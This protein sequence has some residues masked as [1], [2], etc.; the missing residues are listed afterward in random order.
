M[1]TGKGLGTDDKRH[2]SNDRRRRKSRDRT[3][4][5]TLE[6]QARGFNSI[7]QATGQ[8]T[9]NFETMAFDNVKV[10]ADSRDEV[11]ATLVELKHRPDIPA[12]LKANVDTGAQGNVLPLRT[13]K[14]M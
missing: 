10:G 12:T 1:P 8:L 6:D 9:E 14:R 5:R 11:Y 2:Q 7:S 4:Y 3:P 13:Y